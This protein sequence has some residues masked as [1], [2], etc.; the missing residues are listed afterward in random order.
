[1]SDVLLDFEKKSLEFQLKVTESPLSY[2]KQQCVQESRIALAIYIP[3]PILMKWH[4][5]VGI[6]DER[7]NELNYTYLVLQSSPADKSLHKI[8][9]RSAFKFSPSFQ[10]NF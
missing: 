9:F 1:M 10:M 4:E 5:L 8:N 7:G 3:Y 6:K 2:I